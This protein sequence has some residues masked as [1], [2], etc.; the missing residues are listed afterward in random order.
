MPYLALIKPSLIQ[1]S[2]SAITDHYMHEMIQK[3]KPYTLVILHK[4]AKLND[5]GAK[6][7]VWEHGRRN[8]E[9]RSDGKL[10]IVC[11]VRDDSD[12]SGVG[13]FS[14]NLEDT[15]KIMDEDPAVKAGILLYE[16]HPTS[17][18]PGDSLPM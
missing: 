9:L 14:T 8:F 2:M 11:P 12:I 13:V 17:S 4:T 10:N 1:G 16:M 6:E 5:V 15:R 7:I 3:T 18:F